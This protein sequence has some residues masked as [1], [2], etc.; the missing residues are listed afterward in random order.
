MLLGIVISQPP[1][2]RPSPTHP[3]LSRQP[4]ALALGGGVALY[5]LGDLCFRRVMGIEPTMFR[6]C[7]ALLALA[8]IPVGSF[9]MCVM[10]LARSRGYLDR[11]ALPGNAKHSTETAS[12]RVSDFR[13]TLPLWEGPR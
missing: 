5:L 12:C 4:F 11:H 13:L 2:R 1:S 7:G 6:L 9:V 3:I 8:A 10:Q